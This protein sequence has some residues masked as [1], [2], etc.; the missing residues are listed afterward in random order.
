MI[1]IENIIG[2]VKND[3][4]WLE[5]TRG[6]QHD[7]LALEQW[8]AQKSRCRKQSERGFDIGIALDRRVRL[9]DGDILLC[10]DDKKYLLTVRITLREMLVIHLE[11]LADA[12]FMVAIGRVFELGHALGNQ[13]WKAVIKGTQVYV[14][15]TVEKKMMSSVMK[16][17]GYSELDYYFAPGKTVLPLLT[18]SESRL[19]FGGAE[20]SHVHVSV[21]RE[22]PHHDD[23]HPHG[24]HYD[25]HD[26]AHH[27]HDGK[28]HEHKH[29]PNNH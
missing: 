25:D 3:P 9:T 26:H 22:H 2:N 21:I 11:S 8:E 4:S 12:G 6:Y 19:L 29:N 10:D 13:H 27:G 23:S 16:T 15:L 7:M 1:L 17:H 28:E 14:P 5:K 18:P 24:H 20:D